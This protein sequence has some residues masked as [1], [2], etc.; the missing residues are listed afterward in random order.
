VCGAV[1]AEHTDML[2]FLVAS[3]ANIGFWGKYFEAC[4]VTRLGLDG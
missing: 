3:G 4:F 2:R 1:K